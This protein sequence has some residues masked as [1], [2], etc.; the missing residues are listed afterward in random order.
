MQIN[1]NKQNNSPKF[2]M[3]INS[4]EIVDKVIKSRI[5]T[6]EQ[7]NKLN[8]IMD[9]ESQNDVID[10]AL[11]TDG[12]LLSANAYP[13]HFVNRENYPEYCKSFSENKFSK[14]F[15]GVVGFIEKTAKFADDTAKEI[16]NNDV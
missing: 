8:Q 13:R 11:F 14:I 10:I 3:A 2:G 9:K 4:S 12:K 15:Q 7:L 6:P 5:K 1:L 16:K